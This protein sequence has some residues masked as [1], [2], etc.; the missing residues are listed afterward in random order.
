MK[1]KGQILSLSLMI[2]FISVFVFFIYQLNLNL[3]SQNIATGF[4]FLDY[5]AGFEISE[6]LISYD[7][8]DT[9]GK[10]LI[11]GLL[12]TI[13]MAVV[14]CFFAF[15][16][17]LIFGIMGISNNDAVKGFSAT[18][19]NVTRN[20]PL[21]LQ[22]FFWYAL[23]TDI[24]PSV[25]QAS[26]VGGLIFSNRGFYF[27]VFKENS[28]A[29][30]WL[31]SSISIAFIN[32]YLHLTKV[33]SYRVYKWFFSSAFVIGLLTFAFGL[34]FELSNPALSGFNIEGGKYLSPEFCSL[35]L[36]LTIYTGAFMAE[37]IRAGI[38][39][40]PK[41]QWEAARSL[42]LSD[43]NVLRFVIVP[44]SFRISLPPLISR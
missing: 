32:G 18:Y 6:S 29:S 1:N 10:A 25:R 11:V 31:F 42:G 13:K 21:L 33:K 5:E 37:I 26:P 38:L 30:I 27:P 19:V 22:L 43:F 44:Q 8:F 15:I 3:S 9:Y 24:F 35:F 28:I 39:A 36:G 4:G 40:I 7:S 41:G 16:L 20:I 17:G 2:T 34:S 14:G 12:N 23:F